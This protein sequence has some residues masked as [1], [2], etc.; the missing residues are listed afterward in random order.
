MAWLLSEIDWKSVRR[1]IRAETRSREDHQPLISLYRWWARRPHT[2]IGAILDASDIAAGDG[3][4]LDPF[5]GG[6][7]VAIEAARR[8]IPVYAQDLN[9]WAAWGLHIT[10][11]P[12]SSKE[13]RAAG[14]DFLAR[15]RAAEGWRY[16]LS[17]E[18]PAV[19]HTFR[20]RTRCCRECST[21]YWDFPYGLLSVASRSAEE[22]HGYYGCRKCGLASKH[23]LNAET[24]RCPDCTYALVDRPGRWCPECK[25]VTKTEGRPLWSPVMVQRFLEVQDGR[26]VYLDVPSAIEA[27]SRGP[28]GSVPEA[29]DAP[30]PLG[31]ETAKLIRAG[32]RTWSDLYPRRQLQVLL[33]AA[34]LIEGLDVKPPVRDRLMLALAGAT[35]MPGYLCRW[36][37]YHP[38]AFEALSNHRYSFDGLAIEPNLLAPVGRGSLERRINAS[39]VAAEWAEA[40]LPKS[41]TV[42]Y[43]LANCKQPIGKVTAGVRIVQGSSERLLLEDGSASLVVTDPP[44]Y[45]S[46]QYG[47]LA[48]LFLAWTKAMG[49]APRCGVFKARSEA[50]P[51]RSRRSGLQ[52]YQRKLQAIFS[53]CNRA[54][55]RD[56][57]LVL[58]FHCTDLRA[59]WALGNSLYENGFRIGAIV[60]AETENGAD[61]AKRGTRA[62]V[63]DLLVECERIRPNLKSSRTKVLRIPRTPEERELVRVGLAMAEVKAGEYAK[64]REVFIR[65]CSRMRQRRIETPDV[66]VKMSCNRIPTRSNLIATKAAEVQLNLIGCSNPCEHLASS[67]LTVEADA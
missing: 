8:S 65:R 35:E 16:R 25:R 37:R 56:G 15:L 54:L 45:D 24:L 57:K 46:V 26:V 52:A 53:Q 62:F 7:T 59:W 1:G 55:R 13:L 31:I 22:T 5:S 30:I 50:V 29:L 47:E 44:Y 34:R 39:V 17:S 60:A 42:N 33:S 40:N 41:L 27:V 28:N 20:V 49:L 10:L 14:E 66:R 2:L 43:A 32:F 21:K 38:K 9:P 51:N 61:H 18:T 12:V 11:A 58:T 67:K 6:G 63:S 48:S 64:L 3:L 23:R 36:D 4:V 19:A